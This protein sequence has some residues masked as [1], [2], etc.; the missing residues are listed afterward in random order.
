MSSIKQIIKYSVVGI[1]INSIGYIF[2]IILS[3]VIGI[4]PSISAILSGITAASLSYYLNAN[5]TFKAKNK[6]RK[7][8]LNYF[9]LYVC[10]IF[11]HSF[12]IFIF[13]NIFNFAHEI[14]AGISLIIISLSLFLIQK[15]YL[16]QK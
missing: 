3:N 1:L 16:F 8:A 13:S 15:F 9:L 7:I 5:F 6:G 2:Y 10:A 4:N 14:V 12:S 11:I